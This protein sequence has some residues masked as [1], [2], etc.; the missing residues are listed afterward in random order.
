MFV[1][2]PPPPPPPPPLMP[3]THRKPS[4]NDCIST[5][6]LDKV[7]SFINSNGKDCVNYKEYKHH[8]SPLMT[9]T[10]EGHLAIVKE[11]LS[12]GANVNEKD[13]NGWT[14]LMQAF[15]DGHFEIFKQLITSGANVNDKDEMD[16]K[17]IL[18]KASMVKG[19]LI[20]IQELLKAGAN[21]NEQDESGFT[22]LIWTVLGGERVKENTKALLDAGADI[23]IKDKA[24]FTALMW[25]ANVNSPEI[26]KLLLKAGAQVDHQAY[27]SSA[28]RE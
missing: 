11:L 28:R 24:Q 7:K 26:L 8:S 10:A 19:A 17:S 16:C 21:I 3:I 2:T 25:A 1:Q 13:E 23:N 4:L 18:I 14:A 22:A 5:G 20:I 12:C 27:F 6:N 9:A 15:V